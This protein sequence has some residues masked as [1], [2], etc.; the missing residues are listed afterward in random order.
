M[1]EDLNVPFLGGLP[2]EPLVARACDEGVNFIQ[3]N[4]NSP[5]CKALE[6][7]VKG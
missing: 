5:T 2:I 3:E 6:N 4:P 7:V 1:C